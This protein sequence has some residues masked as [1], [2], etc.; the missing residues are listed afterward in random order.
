MPVD[1]RSIAEDIAAYFLEKAAN[2]YD[3]DDEPE[4]NVESYDSYNPKRPIE[5][6]H[7]LNPTFKEKQFIISELFR[8]ADEPGSGYEVCDDTFRHVVNVIL[9]NEPKGTPDHELDAKDKFFIEHIMNIKTKVYNDEYDGYY[10]HI[11]ALLDLYIEMVDEIWNFKSTQKRT[12][13]D[14]MDAIEPP[15]KRQSP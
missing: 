3:D 11:G 10:E 4:T 8:Q 14:N 2:Y 9:T 15:K 5:T 7:L 6:L 12:R 13:S 1:P